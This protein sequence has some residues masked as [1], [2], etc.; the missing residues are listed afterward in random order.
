MKV[1]ENQNNR[2][3]GHQSTCNGGFI[4]QLKVHVCQK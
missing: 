3:K 1:T 2:H 4:N